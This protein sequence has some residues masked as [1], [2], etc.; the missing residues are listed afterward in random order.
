VVA[1]GSY[2]SA[3][4]QTLP[5][6]R[7]GHSLIFAHASRWIV[8]RFLVVAVF[9]HATDSLYSYR[10]LAELRLLLQIFRLVMILRR[11]EKISPK[12][13]GPFSLAPQPSFEVIGF[14]HLCIH[15]RCFG[16]LIF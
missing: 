2:R 16:S 5:S 12:T 7:L 4:I 11:G 6:L 15:R 9:Y 10:W 1:L 8:G 3:V 13:L 14:L